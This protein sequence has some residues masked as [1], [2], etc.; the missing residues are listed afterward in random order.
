[1]A[2]LPSY[3]L[4]INYQDYSDQLDA[5]Q[6]TDQLYQAIVNTPFVKPFE[7]AY[8]FLGIVVFLKVNR[9]E[10]TIDRIALSRTEL[11]KNTTDV[12]VVP[13]ESIKIPIDDQE[14]IIAIA[15][16][17][18]QIR[19]TTD[20]KFLF[21]PTLTPE[22][23][24]INQASGGI[25]YSAVCPLDAGDGAAL[26]FSYYQYQGDIGQAQHEFMKT[27]RDLV[28]NKLDHLGS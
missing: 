18:N 27:Y 6:S 4:A 9:I 8:L 23:A 17:T 15:I 11:A 26:I 2:K 19:D 21:S 12:S 7:T 14:N 16:R 5:A 10:G 3:S 20:W 25:A 24:R 22:A 28:N 1:V 13:F